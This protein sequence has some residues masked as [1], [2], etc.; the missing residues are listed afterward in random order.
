MPSRAGTPLAWRSATRPLSLLEVRGLG[1]ELPGDEP[2]DPDLPGL[3]VGPVHAV[4][5]D[6]RLRHDYDLA[7][8]G[9]IGEDLLVAAHGGVEDHLSEARAAGH[10]TPFVNR[11][12]FEHEQSGASRGHERDR[13]SSRASTLI[14]SLSWL[15]KGRACE[16]RSPAVHSVVALVAVLGLLSA[17]TLA[18]YTVHLKDGTSIVAKTKYTVQ[19]DKVIIVLPSG[20][21]TAL[22]LVELDFDKTEAA[23][24]SDL[25]NAIVI[26][27]GKA[28]NLTQ[29][30]PPPPRK[31][32]LKDLL[33]QRAAAEGSTTTGAV[34]LDAAPS[35]QNQ[36]SG[37]D[38]PQPDRRR[39]ATSPLSTEIR[40]F[41]FG[42]GITNLEVQQGATQP[43]AAPGVPDLVGDAGLSR[44]PGERRRA[45][46]VPREVSRPGGRVRTD[47]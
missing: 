9:G 43:Q 37:A 22:P 32:T 42:R 1:G 21:E 38:Q 20:T 18:A 8:V 23:N 35:T 26:E 14:L 17:G 46:P 3:G 6:V 44:D 24:R 25:G 34:A 5:A 39:C 36:R 31:Q 47:L 27:N 4:V 40:T 19:G 12:V 33:Q 11:A 30:A 45:D 7:A 13:S 41:I 15:W 28:T 2:L 29:D 16:D 10:G